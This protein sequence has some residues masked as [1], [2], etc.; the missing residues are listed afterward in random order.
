MIRLV[1]DDWYYLFERNSRK[2]AI[3]RNILVK[4]F[5]VT[6]QSFFIRVDNALFTRENYAI[7]R[8]ARYCT[9]KIVNPRVNQTETETYERARAKSRRTGTVVIKKLLYDLGNV[10]HVFGIIARPTDRSAVPNG[11]SVE[12]SRTRAS[13]PEWKIFRHV[14]VGRH[15][16][17]SK[18]K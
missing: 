3:D 2:K 11:S 4:L 16:N 1:V 18:S 13:R 14:L 12:N 5:Y 9:C 15:A 8:A 6:V 10:P 7:N 17:Y